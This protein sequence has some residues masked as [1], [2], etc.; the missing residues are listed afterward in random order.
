MSRKGDV[1]I[2]I[3]LEMAPEH[4]G[5]IVQF[6]VL[7]ADDRSMNKN[8]IEGLFSAERASCRR[9]RPPS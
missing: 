7:S 5:S 3:V 6:K 4:A 8:R 9:H 2:H 1:D